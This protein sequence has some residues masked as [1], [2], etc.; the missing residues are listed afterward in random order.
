MNAFDRAIAAHSAALQR[1][2]GYDV[3]IKRGVRSTETIVGVLSSSTHEV[4][5]E[6]EQIATKVKF[7]DW[8]F[9]K[10]ELV[11][12]GKALTPLPGDLIVTTIREVERTFRVVPIERRPCFEPHDHSGLMVVVHTI[13]IC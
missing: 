13:E 1:V 7:S 8:L 9:T 12:N 10:S 4:F 3:V 2:A 5:D 6:A 11:L